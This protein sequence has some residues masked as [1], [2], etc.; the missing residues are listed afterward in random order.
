MGVRSLLERI[1]IDKVG[2][3]NSFAANVKAFEE[4]GYVS[5]IQKE[6]LLAILEAGHATIHR[7]FE[8]TRKDIVIL[9]DIAEHII[10]SVYVHGNKVQDLAM[11][12]PKR[13]SGN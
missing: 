12:V 2:D 6:R 3:Q 13:P 9:I 5:S 8:P 11:R 1:I 10:E 7:N 4:A